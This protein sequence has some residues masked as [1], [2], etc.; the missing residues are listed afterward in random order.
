MTENMDKL[1]LISLHMQIKITIY[2]IKEQNILI[3]LASP[4][5]N[6]GYFYPQVPQPAGSSLPRRVPGIVW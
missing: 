3:N 1:F 2:K 5:N 4:T 6:T